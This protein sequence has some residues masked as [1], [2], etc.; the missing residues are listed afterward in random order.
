MGA[1]DI[2][3][4]ASLDAIRQAT[5]I[6]DLRIY[7]LP[8]DRPMYDLMGRKIENRKSVNRKFPGIIISSG[9]KYIIK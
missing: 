1:E 4:E 5:E 3:L 7:D 2:H 8:L 9:K 6:Y